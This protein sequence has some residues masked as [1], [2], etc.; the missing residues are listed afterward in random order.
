MLIRL[1]SIVAFLFLQPLGLSPQRAYDTRTDIPSHINPTLSPPRS[2]EEALK[3]FNLVDGFTIELI[4]AEPLIE[5]PILMEWDMFGRLWVCEMRGFMLDVN[6]TGELEEIGRIAVLE[7]T[8]QD[9]SLDKVTH[10]AEGLV[11]PR[12]MRIYQE[13]LLVGEHDKLWF[14][15]DADN[16]LVPDD[17]ILVDAEYATSGSVEHRANGLLIGL[18]NWV[19][20]SNSEKRYK[21]VDDE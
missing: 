15:T 13:G 7:D 21:R 5:D 1:P 18:D 4:A 2:P 16:D 20:N 19:Y 11:L 8:N 12:A 10:F 9:G 17:K 14:Y 6:A 3:S